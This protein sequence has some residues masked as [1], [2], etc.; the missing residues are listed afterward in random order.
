MPPSWR[1]VT[2]ITVATA[3][4]SNATTEMVRTRPALSR[5]PTRPRWHDRS[6]DGA[7]PWLDHAGWARRLGI[8]REAVELY[9]ASEV[10]DLHVESFVW[11]RVFGYDLNCR[12]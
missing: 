3:K 12:H 11:T 1:A 8:S 5:R 7:S 6:T 4:A 2:G 10:V 9:L